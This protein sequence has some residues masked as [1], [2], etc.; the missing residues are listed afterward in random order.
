[1]NLKELYLE[2]YRSRPES[3]L[4][5]MLV[6][7]FV[8]ALLTLLFGSLRA[9]RRGWMWFN[10]MVCIG[11]YQILNTVNGLNYMAVILPRRHD[12]RKYGHQEYEDPENDVNIGHLEVF[13]LLC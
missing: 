10:R 13:F 5:F 11:D 3:I 2:I 4:R 9:T 8:W 7:L 12:V 1:M 6:S